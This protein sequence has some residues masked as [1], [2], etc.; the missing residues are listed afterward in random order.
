MM[1]VEAVMPPCARAAPAV[2]TATAPTVASHDLDIP[3]ILYLHSWSRTQDEG[4]VRAALEAYGIP[5]TYMGDKEIAKMP[6]L[7]EQYDVIIYPHTGQSGP[8]ILNGVPMTGTNPIPYMKT[9]Q[10]PSFGTPDATSDIRGGMGMEGLFNLYKF[11][12]EGG[13]YIAEGSTSTLFPQFNFSPGVTV[14][15]TEGLFARGIIVRGNIPDMRNPL[16]YGLG[17]NQMA[18]YFNGGPVLN[19]GGTGGFGGGRGGR[20]SSQTQNIQPNANL[21]QV[22][23]FSPGGVPVPAAAS[24]AGTGGRGGRGGAAGGGGRGAAAA[25]A[26]A[27][28][29]GGAAGA[30]AAAA[31]AGV[32]PAVIAAAMAGRGGGRGGQ[33]GAA[34]AS[35][36]GPRIALQ[37]PLDATE[38]LLSGGLEN[39]EQ[40]SGRAQVVTSQI[41]EGYVVMFSIRPFWR[42]QTHGTYVLGFNAIMNWND[43]NAGRSAPAAAPGGGRGGRGGGQ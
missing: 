36:T 17:Y 29:A 40:L 15:Q 24:A 12:Q 38:M 26:A 31:A 33:G 11:V 41:G 43:L 25:A 9:P 27:G 42:W 4:W 18:V 5:F 8:N 21:P 1:I 3:R 37:F 7:R 35:T 30:A 14:E 22:N 32:D 6:N 28:A 2:A 34:A 23:A 19:A 10:T 20:G 16:V 39:G 13:T